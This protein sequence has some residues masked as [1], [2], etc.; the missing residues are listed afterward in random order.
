MR[1][2]QIGNATL[3]CG[4]CLEILPEIS[5]VGCVVT[6]PP[7]MLR[8][9]GDY[10]N[11]LNPWADLCNGAVFISAWMR[12]A[13][14]TIRGSAAMWVF[15]N[16]R[17]LPAFQKAGFEC[18]APLESLLVWDKQ[19]I[20]PGSRGLR[21]QY[22][23]VGFYPVNGFGIQN[24]GISDIWSEKWSSHKP[25]GHPAEKPQG[26][27]SRLLEISVPIQG[28]VLDP[29]M[30][31]GTTGAA[32]IQMGLPFIGIEIDPQWFD[33]ACRRVEASLSIISA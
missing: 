11:K 22:E 30:G 21:P 24:R 20:G 10:K 15:S 5:G 33:A 16:W 25:H 28:A 4:D 26:L 14:G 13:L 9:A 17:G 19:Y 29:F 23:L 7:Y 3:Y 18:R 27:V 6:D 32:A 8:C 2:E 1:C 31:S 12:L